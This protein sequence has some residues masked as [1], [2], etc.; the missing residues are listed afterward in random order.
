MAT[1]REIAVRIN[2]TTSVVDQ[3]NDRYVKVHVAADGSDSV[4]DLKKKICVSVSFSM[5]RFRP[6]EFSGQLE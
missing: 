4:A 3:P 5:S 2:H 6:N 1:T